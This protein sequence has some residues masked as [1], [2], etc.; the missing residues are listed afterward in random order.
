MGE[1][2][3]PSAKGMEFQFSELIPKGGIR[4]QWGTQTT[5]SGILTKRIKDWGSSQGFN[6]EAQ[7]ERLEREFNMAAA[8]RSPDEGDLKTGHRSSAI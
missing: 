8:L 4:S 5:V 3:Q 7:E 1:N 2:D 6:R